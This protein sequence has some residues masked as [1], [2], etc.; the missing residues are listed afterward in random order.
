MTAAGRAGSFLGASEFVRSGRDAGATPLPVK[1]VA[2]VLGLYA[3]LPIVG[4]APVATEGFEAAVTAGV[5]QP[6]F[7][8]S[9]VP[10]PLY[11][12]AS[13]PGEFLLYRLSD[14]IAPVDALLTGQFW[15]L[16]AWCCGL[17]GVVLLA[18]RAGLS[19]PWTAALAYFT[20]FDLASSMGQVSSSNLATG[21]VALGAGLFIVGGVASVVAVPV[22]AA[23]AFCRL[24][25][26]ALVPFALL[27]SALAQPSFWRFLIRAVVAGLAVGGL[28]LLFYAAAGL[29]VLQTLHEGNAVAFEPN[30]S[31]I[32]QAFHKFPPWTWAP[33]LLGVTIGQV[34]TWRKQPLLA[35]VRAV[36]ILAPA[37]VM[38]VVY[39]GKLS[40]PRF[41]APA[42]TLLAPGTA[43]LIEAVIAARVRT[44]AASG[45]L[46]ALCVVLAWF[47]RQP[48]E[49][50]DGFRYK[51]A[52]YLAPYEMFREKRFLDATN[53][54][55]VSDALELTCHE[56]AGQ[57]LSILSIEWRQFN[58]VVRWLVL[59]GAKLTDAGAESLADGPKARV[60][61]FN[62]DGRTVSVYLFERG[63]EWKTPAELVAAV[64]ELQGRGRVDVLVS[65][66]GLLKALQ[67][68][69]PS[70]TTGY[71]AEYDHWAWH[72][73][74]LSLH[75]P[76]KS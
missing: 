4:V 42:T 43:M 35:F 5:N 11:S 53:P 64:A 9:P 20:L 32:A 47:V 2:I 65:D 62:L 21:L 27:F 19:R 52:T 74:Q 31:P 18:T 39:L 6:F 72:V 24:D 26:L 3:L 73:S 16:V 23:G 50:W 66:V 69:L 38:I 70:A 15:S 12:Y 46:L 49:V 44:R 45:V 34:G 29:S 71:A 28:V 13:R 48:F 51:W 61:R 55:M 67:P 57:D 41:M 1:I 54:A 56:C 40:S 30:V 58:E 10:F 8:P 63:R 60:Y 37:A 75:L 33:P 36:A 7:A 22:L 76:R 59:D 17:A 68:A 25:M 14:A